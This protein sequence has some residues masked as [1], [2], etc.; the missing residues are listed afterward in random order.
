[1]HKSNIATITCQTGVCQVCFA[2]LYP[3]CMLSS[4]QNVNHCFRLLVTF[5]ILC[6]GPSSAAVNRGR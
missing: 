1:M 6:T 3:L 5:Q 2:M 4:F